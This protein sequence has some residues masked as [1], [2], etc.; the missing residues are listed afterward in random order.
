MVYSLVLQEAGRLHKK[1]GDVFTV[2]LKTC[3]QPVIP[4]HPHPHPGAIGALKETGKY[5]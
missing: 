1:A 4:P 2:H 3:L 5:Q